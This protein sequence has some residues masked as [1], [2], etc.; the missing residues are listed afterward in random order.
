MKKNLFLILLLALFTPTLQAENT[1]PFAIFEK[2]QETT[3]DNIIVS[4][5]SLEQAIGM[6]A[7]GAIGATLPPLLELTGDESLAALN[8]RNQQMA[9]L[10]SQHKDDTLSFMRVANSVWHLPTIA[11]QQPFTD[12]VLVR[13]NA[14]I[15]TANFATQ[16]GINSVN[17][18][19]CNNTDSLIEKIL[20]YPDPNLV[21]MLINATLFHGTW[22]WGLNP[23]LVGKQ[24]FRN[25]NGSGTNVE[26]VSL[27]P[28]YLTTVYLDEELVAASAGFIGED[29][30]SHYRVLFILPRDYQNMVPLTAQR[31]HNLL[32]H[33][34]NQYIHLQVPKFDVSCNEEM[35]PRLREMGA[36][37]PNVFSGIAPQAFVT[38]IIHS[39]RMTLD[40]E[41]MSAAA[42]TAMM[43]TTGEPM[44]IQYIDFIVNR[45]FYV[46]IMADGTDEPIFLAK[47]NQLE[48]AACAAP[49]AQYITLGIENQRESTT[50]TKF[51]RNGQF[52]I[53]TPQGTFTAT[54]Q[55]TE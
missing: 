51:L 10:L 31:W 28:Q 15:D 50:N 46:A 48:G 1:F 25:A 40:E 44:P 17:A 26:M 7:N 52:F 38:S 41:G 16:Q 55:R 6:S 22:E 9:E 14:R 5:F 2:M 39:T 27:R 12:S 37:V 4:P 32:E 19:V 18:W 11:L 45:P 53:Q 36:F 20:N 47:I 54:G 21:V 29:Y 23:Y 13:Y 42:V 8:Q 33:R 30:S 24:P 35:L 43:C 3:E 34:Q 49:N